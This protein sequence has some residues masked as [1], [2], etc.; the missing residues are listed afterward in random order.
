L[1][2]IDTTLGPSSS[3][4]DP[5]DWTGHVIVC[6]LHVN[7]L[8][9]IELLIATGTKVVVLDDDP[10]KRLVP[11]L[12]S[13]SVPLLYR[14][15]G[16]EEF[17]LAGL[18]GASAVICAESSDLLTL[19]T[20][21]LVRDF[22]EDV[23][24]I[25]DIDNPSV[26]KAIEGVTGEGSV[27]DVAGLFAP[28]VVS[29][30]MG[31]DTDH[32]HLG[33]QEFVAATVKID[34]PGTLRSKFG[35]LAPIGVARE[36]SDDVLIGPS[37]DLEVEPGDR[38]CVIGTPSDLKA[39]KIVIETAA[40]EERGF[41]HRQLDRLSRTWR[42]ATEHTDSAL[43]VTL[44]LGLALCVF[45]ALMLGLFYREPDGTHLTILQAIYFTFETGATVG[46]GDFSFAQQTQAMQVFGILLIIVST[47]IVSLIFAF[48]TN[49]LISR[50]I[51]QSLGQ[52]QVHEFRGHTVLIGLG[53]VGM[54]VIEGLRD[55]GRDVAVI[56]RNS[57]NSYIP[58]ARSLGVPVIIGDAT[59]G[60][61]LDS[62]NLDMAS[63]VAVMTSSDL[64]NI[65]TSL[66]VRGKL[67]DRWESTPVVVR[68]FDRALA[69]R[70]SRSFGFQHVWASASIAAP[71]FV[72]AAVGLEVLSTFYFASE[73]F[74]VATLEVSEEGGLTGAT[75]MD[76][77]ADVRVIA[78]DRDDN[79]EYP[80]RRDT[81]FV[82]GDRAYLAGPYEELL[83]VMRRDREAA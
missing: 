34:E 53:S 81:K 55:Q 78:I 62:V 19:Q 50:R 83:R 18:N 71:W 51:E 58:L 77:G 64:T 72:G 75:M 7:S 76:L 47:V 45:A 79:L 80:P 66:A 11:T 8:R 26:G 35:D 20:A 9:A 44:W 29:T 38:A 23:K 49:L 6:G 2:S 5:R 32:L 40:H 61:T 42:I 3:Q 82:A 57:D 73:P 22:R 15:E 43:K 37:R 30:C 27:L 36:D 1:S 46:F 10:D 69:D 63:S 60:T 13:W 68:V 67:G 52:G 16:P 56:E 65:E 48:I 59:L 12:A 31:N 14:G 21:L 28:A 24:V 4:D 25:V 17:M 33:G 41:F 54:R 39:A 74:L 70:L